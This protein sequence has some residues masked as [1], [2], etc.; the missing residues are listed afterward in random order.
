MPDNIFPCG[1]PR[2]LYIFSLF[3]VSSVILF[4]IFE[5]QF[6]YLSTFTHANS[7]SS[8]S[9]SQVNPSFSTSAKTHVFHKSFPPR[10][11]YPTR[12]TDFWRL[13]QIFSADRFLKFFSCINFYFDDTWQSNLF[14]PPTYRIVTYDIRR[15]VRHHTTAATEAHE[16]AGCN[17]VLDLRISLLDWLHQPTSWRHW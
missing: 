15:T 10:T 14:L 7:S 3:I 1:I 8:L 12:R 9:L 11:A 13:S 2:H 5:I 4:R 16:Q 17:N 6:R